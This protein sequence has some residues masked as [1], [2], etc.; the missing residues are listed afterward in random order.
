MS[1]FERGRSEADNRPT[2]VFNT[3]VRQQAVY[4]SGVIAFLVL[5]CGS[6]RLV[7]C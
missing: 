5:F 6:I 4:L 1:V 3:L 7:I 2:L